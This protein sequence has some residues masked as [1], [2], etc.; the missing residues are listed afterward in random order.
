MHDFLL[1]ILYF[2]QNTLTPPNKLNDPK[3]SDF[4][5]FIQ[6]ATNYFLSL[7][8]LTAIF[9]IVLGAFYYAGGYSVE[10]KQKGKSMIGYAV[11]GLVVVSLSWVIIHTILKILGQS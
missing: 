5:L 3:L 4:P 1:Q 8:G 2:A 7:A 6:T 11:G 9:F 10:L